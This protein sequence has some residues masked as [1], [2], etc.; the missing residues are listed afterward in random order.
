M[1]EHEWARERL[2]EWGRALEKRPPA[3]ERDAILAE[4]S[5][6]ERV[7]AE[8]VRPQLIAHQL[9]PPDYIWRELGER[10]A[11]PGMRK[12]WEHGVSQIETFRHEHGVTDRSHAFGDPK[13]P[14]ERAAREQV[15][16]RLRETQRALGM[17]QARERQAERGMEIG[18]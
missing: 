17:R 5:T 11:D 10:P 15:Q 9:A 14:H 1:R 8:R 6:V 4:L 7:L 18:L 3:N 2:A 16:R 13:T 12:S